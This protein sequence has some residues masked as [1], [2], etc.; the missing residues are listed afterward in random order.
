MVL[1]SFPKPPCIESY[2]WEMMKDRYIAE[3]PQSCLDF[4]TQSVE[5]Q[6]L[7]SRMQIQSGL[8]PVQVSKRTTTIRENT[9]NIQCRCCMWI[10]IIT[11]AFIHARAEGKE[12]VQ[13]PLRW[14]DLVSG[15]GNGEEGFRSRSL[16]GQ[17]L[18]QTAEKLHQSICL[19]WNHWSLMI[20]ATKLLA[21]VLLLEID[22]L[23][24]SEKGAEAAAPSHCAR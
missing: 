24:R 3:S 9:V 17:K 20:T 4:P 15:W 13:V 16:R 10:Q 22:H 18:C 1:F 14:E 11:K 7:E 8:S 21:S 12:I 2:W 5:W 6:W 23:I 19:R